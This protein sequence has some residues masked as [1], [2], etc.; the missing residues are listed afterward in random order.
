MCARGVII[1]TRTCFLLVAP[2]CCC[3]F[4]VLALRERRVGGTA[5]SGAR[6]GNLEICRPQRRLPLACS[7]PVGSR[8]HLP[9]IDFID[10]Q[11]GRREKSQLLHG[12]SPLSHVS[13]GGRSN[14]PLPV[15]RCNHSPLAREQ[16]L[17]SAG[18]RLCVKDG[19]RWELRRCAGR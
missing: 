12:P 13:S 10:G 18:S 14:R 15:P 2:C 9:I 4:S 3:C 1:F 5:D 7:G 16:P 17:A 11:S 6:D 8:R 19:R